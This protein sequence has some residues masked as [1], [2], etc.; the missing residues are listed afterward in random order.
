MTAFR[1]RPIVSSASFVLALAALIAAG[2][3]THASQGSS[4][5]SANPEPTQPAADPI[6]TFRAAELQQ[7]RAATAA[8]ISLLLLPS[9]SHEQIA[10]L[11]SV[12]RVTDDFDHVSLATHLSAA[13]PAW[14]QTLLERD[15]GSKGWADARDAAGRLVLD[16]W[17]RVR[18]DE[19]DAATA[20][21]TLNVETPGGLPSG[22]DPQAVADPGQRAAYERAIAA[23]TRLAHLRANLDQIKAE[24]ARY[25]R[26]ASGML[27]WAFSG[28][29]DGADRLSELARQAGFLSEQEIQALISGIRRPPGK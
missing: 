9:R 13:D 21:P 18:Q 16:A 17:K 20:K 26:E 11:V 1:P 27:G 7:A 25:G 23:N 12:R 4:A 6:G 29:A 19:L 22:A 15:L 10:D 5:M 24:S 14:L 28:A 2:A 8:L 3:G